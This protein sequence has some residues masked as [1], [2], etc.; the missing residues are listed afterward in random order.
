MKKLFAVLGATVLFASAAHATKTT[1]EYVPTEGDTVTVQYD[2]STMTSKNVTSG[3]EGTYT[4]DE[5]TATVCGTG[6]EG[7]EVCA[8]FENPGTEVGHE[9]P[10]TTN[11]GRSGTAK[12][13]AVEE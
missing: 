4:Y 3:N 1:I 12:I 7:A 6:A 2:D 8:T 9:T 5:E 13:T 11:D 10:F